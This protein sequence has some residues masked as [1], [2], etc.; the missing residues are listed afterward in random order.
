[1]VMLSEYYDVSYSNNINIGLATVTVTGKVRYSGE[2]KGSFAIIANSEQTKPVNPTTESQTVTPIQQPTTQNQE[3]THSSTTSQKPHTESG[4]GTISAD[5][6]ILTDSDGVMY[7]VSDKMSNSQLIKNAHVADKKSGGKFK[8]TKVTKKNGKIVGGTAKYMAPYNKNCT[9]T[10]I[11]NNVKICGVKFKVT[12][13][14][15]NAFKNCKK[16]KKATIGTNV[17]KIGL[18]AFSGCF[19]LKTVVIKST[20][21]RSIGSNAFKDIAKKATFT[22]PKKRNITYPKM[23]KNAKAPKNSKIKTK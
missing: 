18:G 13:L 12:E 8:I 5:G 1:M 17:T 22:I 6:T 14:N 16:L 2:L 19:R 4:V 15:S 9:V 20:V 3:N 10:Y 23:I 7:H 11:P 21:I